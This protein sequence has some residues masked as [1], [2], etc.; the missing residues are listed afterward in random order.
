[1]LRPI[2]SEIMYKK[3]T[4]RRSIQG[5]ASALLR[6]DIRIFTTKTSDKQYFLNEKAVVPDWKS[7]VHIHSVTQNIRIFANW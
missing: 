7:P 6:M 1:M 3:R 5:D 2:H 4:I